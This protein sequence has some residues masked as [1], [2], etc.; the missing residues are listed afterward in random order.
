M[1]AFS[2]RE[3]QHNAIA[4]IHID[5]ENADDPSL[6]SLQFHNLLTHSLDSM[7]QI[8]EKE[9]AT[10]RSF[11]VLNAILHLFCQVLGTNS[12]DEISKDIVSHAQQ[13]IRATPYANV[14]LFAL[15]FV[16]IFAFATL[17]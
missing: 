2:W 1:L 12:V 6:L 7:M 3:A 13:L 8:V 17:L 9:H 16:F 15:M 10:P 4:L 14:I 5:C 11:L